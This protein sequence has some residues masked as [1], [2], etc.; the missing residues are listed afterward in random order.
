[1]REQ[2]TAGGR[3]VRLSR[4]TTAVAMVCCTACVMAGLAAPSVASAQDLPSRPVLAIASLPPSGLPQFEAPAE[5]APPFLKGRFMIVVNTGQAFTPDEALESTSW[6]IS[7]S[8]RNTPKHGGWSPSFG[9]SWSTSELRAPV[10]GVSTVIGNIRIRPVMLGVG[11]SIIR[12]RVMTNV[13]LTAGYTFNKARITLAM[14]E[15]TAV[16]LRFRDA[17]VARPNVGFTVRLAS[18]LA[19][20]GS[21]SYVHTRPTVTLAVLQNG[22]PV[23]TSSGTIHSDYMSYRV[24]LGYSIF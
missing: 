13:S 9:L 19:L 3:P 2:M 16:D 10:N 24:G 15:G 1:M 21:L 18:R 8:V 20:T 23:F 4:C 5:A 22:V 14:P 7:P 17:W 6:H 11:Y 12:G